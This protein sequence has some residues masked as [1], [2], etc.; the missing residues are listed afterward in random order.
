MDSEVV[1]LDFDP[2]GILDLE[3]SYK[4]F[5]IE[6]LNRLEFG[7][8]AKMKIF[9]NFEFICYIRRQDDTIKIFEPNGKFK[10]FINISKNKIIKINYDGLSSLKDV[11]LSRITSLIRTYGKYIANGKKS[12]ICKNIFKPYVENTKDIRGFTCP[13][14]EI[15]LIKI[16]ENM[17]VGEKVEVLSDC[18]ASTKVFPTI[19]KELGFVSQAYNMGDYIS[20]VFLRIKSHKI[21]NVDISFDSYEQIGL[22]L[23]KFSKIEKIEEYENFNDEILLYNKENIT[24]GSPEGRGWFLISHGYSKPRE[25]RLEY[26]GKTLFNDDALSALNGEKGKFKIFRLVPLN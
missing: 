22:S 16:L 13:L 6:K 24:I 9:K 7:Y 8:E 11:L 17:N 20:Y 26:K 15:S 23:L 10:I 12:A 3:R 2:L 19:A 25:I 21:S 18:V 14:A 1:S 4:L 5:S